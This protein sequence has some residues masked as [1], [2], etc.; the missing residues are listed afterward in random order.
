VGDWGQNQKL[1]VD[2]GVHEVDAS[3]KVE[4]RKVVEE[5]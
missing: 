4:L 3:V 1:G 2:A 5:A